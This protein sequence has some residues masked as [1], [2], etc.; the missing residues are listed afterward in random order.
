MEKKIIKLNSTLTPAFTLIEAANASY[1]RHSHSLY[2]ILYIIDG[3]LEL[4]VQDLQ[5]HLRPGDLAL[6]PGGQVH[7]FHTPDSSRSFVGAFHLEGI[8]EFQKLC[9]GRRL[10]TPYIPACPETREFPEL[11]RKILET[12]VSEGPLLI[13]VGYLHILLGK[14]APLLSFEANDTDGITASLAT[15]A[16]AYIGDNVEKNLTLESVADHLNISKF[17]L[18]RIFNQQL[19]V[20][21]NSFL[22]FLRVNAGK[23]LLVQTDLQISEIA[24][25][26]GFENMRSFNRTFKD[27]AG[28]TPTAYRKGNK[29]KLVINYDNTVM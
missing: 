11:F 22:S 14:L 18:S 8:P 28:Q 27:F 7:G 15:Q 25:I 16:I 21:F 3:Y 20:S 12:S 4:T 13:S 24:M 5:Y 19:N 2:E 6:I 26:C 23:R 10:A 17:Y 1:I 29:G 9:E